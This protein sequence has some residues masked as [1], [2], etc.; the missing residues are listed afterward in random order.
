MLPKNYEGS[1]LVYKPYSPLDKPVKR[2]RFT[3]KQTETLEAYFQQTQHPS[4]VER[5][6]T[7]SK[8]YLST[9]HNLPD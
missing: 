8:A 9:I 6:V 3:I 7:H 1:E 5:F 4:P 2:K